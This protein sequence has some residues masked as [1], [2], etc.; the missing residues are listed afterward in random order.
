MGL[1]RAKAYT[2]SAYSMHLPAPF[3]TTVLHILNVLSV[4]SQVRSAYAGLGRL[5]MI[6]EPEKDDL[7]G[8]RPLVWSGLISSNLDSPGA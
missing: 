1:L 3:S 4:R 2:V 5:D 8:P 7:Q 6:D